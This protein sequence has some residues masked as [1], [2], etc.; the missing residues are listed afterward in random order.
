[1][2]EALDWIKRA[3]SNLALAQ[4]TLKDEYEVFGGEIFFEELCYELQQCAE[5]SIKSIF[6]KHNLEFPKTHNIDQLIKLLK[7][8]SINFPDNLLDVS[9]M[10]QYA[11]R[12][13]YPD[14]IRKIT[15]EEYLEALEITQK[16]YDWAK[17]FILS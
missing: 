2:V 12:T 14:D 9:F 1:M 6:I 11:V 16:V 17:N 15:E 13:R 4:K 7:L 10:T 5:K 3:K 8:N